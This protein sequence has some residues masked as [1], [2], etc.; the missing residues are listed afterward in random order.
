M[1]TLMRDINLFDDFLQGQFLMKVSTVPAYQLFVG[2]DIEDLER[3]HKLLP[4][5]DGDLGNRMFFPEEHAYCRSYADAAV[6]YAGTWCAKEA[7]FKALSVGYVLLASDLKILRESDGR[8]FVD[9][10]HTCFD[11]LKPVIRLSISHCNT[12]AL[13][14]AVAL[15][16]FLPS[17]TDENKG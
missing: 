12:T 9:L 4:E 5:L 7:V 17:S 11:A 6:H 16:P 8:P 2:T 10:S 15:V 13:A 3:W 1:N 14:F